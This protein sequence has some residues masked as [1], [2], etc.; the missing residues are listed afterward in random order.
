MT[1]G[2]PGVSRSRHGDDCKLH[3]SMPFCAGTSHRK[4]YEAYYDGQL[5]LCLRI[6]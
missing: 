4:V 1:N 6:N 3:H 5:T 2:L